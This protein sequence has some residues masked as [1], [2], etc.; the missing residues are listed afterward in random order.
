MAHSR[1]ICIIHSAYLSC[2]YDHYSNLM[3]QIHGVKSVMR[4]FDLSSVPLFLNIAATSVDRTKNSALLPKI[5]IRYL[6]Q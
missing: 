2:I 5:V 4:H 3:R 1:P 6:K